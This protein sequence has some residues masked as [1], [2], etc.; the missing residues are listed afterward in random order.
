MIDPR[1]AGP[2]ES[3]FSLFSFFF[4]VYVSKVLLE[5]RYPL[6][7]EDTKVGKKDT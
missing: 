7:K 1:D 4:L 5:G 6:G 2:W 3:F